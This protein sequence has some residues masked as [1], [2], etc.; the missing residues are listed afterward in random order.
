M[1]VWRE[2]IKNGE[3]D[4]SDDSDESSKLFSSTHFILAITFPIKPITQRE[5]KLGLWS[6]RLLW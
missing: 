5:K 3:V 6:S 4:D 2:S 1:C